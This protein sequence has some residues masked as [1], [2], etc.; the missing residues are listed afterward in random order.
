[1][2]GSEI[3]AQLFYFLLTVFWAGYGL[4][5]V[6]RKRLSMRVFGAPITY[7][8]GYAQA[9]GAVFI[10]S[11]LIL[12]SPL[13]MALIDRTQD[14]PAAY[15]ASLAAALL[16]FAISIL[17]IRIIDIAVTNG[18]LKPANKIPTAQDDGSEWDKPKRKGKPKEKRGAADELQ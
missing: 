2:S 8:G 15:A 6:L 5:A 13:L 7:Q 18:Y 3:G 11:A 14:I 1:M 17:F 12:N 10:I 4:A 9:I 16:V